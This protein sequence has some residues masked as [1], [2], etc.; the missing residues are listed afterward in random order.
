MY[1]VHFRLLFS[2]KVFYSKNKATL[3][4]ISVRHDVVGS[5]R[6]PRKLPFGYGYPSL[7]CLGFYSGFCT[8]TFLIA[9]ISI[10][11]PASSWVA[12][13]WK[14]SVIALGMRQWTVREFSMRH[15]KRWGQHLRDS[16]SSSLY[17]WW[18]L[19]PQPLHWKQRWY[20][21]F[22]S[23]IDWSSY[24]LGRGQ[25]LWSVDTLVK[26]PCWSL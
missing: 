14:V 6:N 16:K 23:M 25:N 9:T 2:V 1:C 7:R 11:W 8:L 4:R 17:R 21:Y 20:Q 13:L 5:S 18:L 10:G 15:R 3:L 19:T 22:E 24:L 12:R 26:V